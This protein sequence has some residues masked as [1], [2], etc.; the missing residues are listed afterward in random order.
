MDVLRD[1][2]A[3]LGVPVLGGLPLGHGADAVAIPIGTEAVLDADSR[4]L[5]L[6]SAFS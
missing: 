6:T 5:T 4:T 3:E 2:L 1:R